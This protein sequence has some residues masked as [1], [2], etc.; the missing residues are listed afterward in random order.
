MPG[1]QGLPKTLSC[2][3]STRG[4]ELHHVSADRCAARRRHQK[5]KEAGQ[6]WNRG[7][8]SLSCLRGTK[9]RGMQA[10]K[11]LTVPEQLF[12]LTRSHPKYIKIAIFLKPPCCASISTIQQNIGLVQGEHSNSQCSSVT[13]LITCPLSL[14]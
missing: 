3:C 5:H 8:S 10:R 14:S 12:C 4:W 13:I 11:G 7:P 9:G 1:N 6:C 2:L